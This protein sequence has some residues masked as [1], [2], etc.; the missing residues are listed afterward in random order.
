MIKIRLVIL[1]QFI[2]IV[3]LKG[4]GEA[5]IQYGKASFYA[6]SFDGKKTANGE[7]YSHTRLTA[8]HLTIPFGTRVKVTNLANKKQVIVRINDRGPYV[9]GRVIDLSKAAATKLDFIQDGVTEVKLEVLKEKMDQTPVVQPEKVPANDF[10]SNKAGYYHVDAS[11]ANPRG[12]GIQV[13]SFR[14]AANLVEILAGFD[15]AFK[16]TTMVQV[17]GSANDRIYR[18]I[19]GSFASREEAGKVKESLSSKYPG[20]FVTGF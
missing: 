20:C 1:I 7:V 14:E 6:D 5:F 17:A 11:V 9:K 13:G 2:A 18:V 19:V 8:A 4:Q 15:D 12:F 10:S 16:S 3:A